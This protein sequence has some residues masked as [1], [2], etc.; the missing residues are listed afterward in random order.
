MGTNDIRREIP[1]ARVIAGMQDII[2]RVKAKGLKIIGATIIP[3][4]NRPASGTNTG[5]DSAKTA[6]RNEVN[7]WMRAKA[8]FD[9]VIDFDKVI[10]DPANP[11]LMLP[12]FNCDDIHPTPRGYYAMGTAVALNLFE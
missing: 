12:A 4:H 10:R 6:R 9:G 8:G 11:D 3:R 5:W 2:T 1:A 7:E